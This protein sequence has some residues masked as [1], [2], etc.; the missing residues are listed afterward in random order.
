MILIDF[1]KTN[2]IFLSLTFFNLKE[3]LYFFLYV[4]FISYTLLFKTINEHEKTLKFL[5]KNKILQID[6]S[7]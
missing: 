4:H 6:I 3:F 5:I 7:N 2:I 1:K